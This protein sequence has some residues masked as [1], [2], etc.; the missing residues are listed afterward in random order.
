MKVGSESGTV[1]DGEAAAGA[2]TIEPPTC[3]KC[4]GPMALRDGRYG[5][6][7]SCLRYPECKGTRNVS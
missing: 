4:G 5:K 6:F 7:W 1:D 3:P 2:T